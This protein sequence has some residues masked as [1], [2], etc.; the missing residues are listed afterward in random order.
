M[1]TGKVI[2]KTKENEA[3]DSDTIKIVN[4]PVTPDNDNKFIETNSIATEEVI[5]YETSVYCSTVMQLAMQTSLQQLL[6]KIQR[7]YA[8]NKKALDRR[9][10]WG[11]GGSLLIYNCYTSTV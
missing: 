1:A 11:E 9:N 3:E 4:I 5:T 7:I 8:S 10:F 2:N 6:K